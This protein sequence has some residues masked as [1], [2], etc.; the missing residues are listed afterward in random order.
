[1]SETSLRSITP[2]TK[3]PAGWVTAASSGINRDW[4]VQWRKSKLLKKGRDYRRV[5]MVCAGGTV[6]KVWI[7]RAPALKK[8]LR[9]H[10][11]QVTPHSERPKWVKPPEGFLRLRAAAKALDIDPSTLLDQSRPG[12]PGS[13][14]LCKPFATTKL[15]ATQGGHLAKHWYLSEI[16]EANR[17]RG[18]PSVSTD[19]DEV[20]SLAETREKTGLPEHVLRSSEDRDR[21]GLVPR[22]GRV[23]SSFKRKVGDSFKWIVRRDRALVFTKESVDQFVADKGTGAPSDGKISAPEAADLLGYHRSTVV[24]LLKKGKLAGEFDPRRGG[25]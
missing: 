6:R 13:P 14:F 2:L 21:L 25:A 5:H 8:L 10:K 19:G 22:D 9:Q 3:P 17:R 4:V 16:N 18:D 24:K 1:M 23:V 20:Y 7:Y 15:P 12:G 11:A